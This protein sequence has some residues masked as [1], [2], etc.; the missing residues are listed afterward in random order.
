MSKFDGC[1]FTIFEFFTDFYGWSFSRKYYKINF[2]FVIEIVKL[3]IFGLAGN[4]RLKWYHPLIALFHCLILLSNIH[5]CFLGNNYI[6]C[7]LF[8]L[9]FIIYFY[10]LFCLTFVI[11]FCLTFIIYFY[12]LF[13]LTF[14]TYFC[15]TFIIYFCLVFFSLLL[16][17]FVYFF[18]S[19]FYILL[20]ILF[21]RFCL[22]L[23]TAFPN[24]VN[25]LI[26]PKSDFYGETANWFYFC[27]FPLIWCKFG[28]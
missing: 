21:L 11:Y 10:R 2:I 12:R 26:K 4:F 22:N 20:I 16:Y 28:I 1:F 7:L 5:A 24:H 27:P 17:I 14:I 25:P 23:S 18:L 19:N 6:F 15:P 3:S 9:T 8:C 13:C